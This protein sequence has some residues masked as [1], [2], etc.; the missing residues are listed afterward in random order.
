MERYKN[1]NGRSKEIKVLMPG[2]G[3]E[4]RDDEIRKRRS[5]IPAGGSDPPSLP[6]KGPRSA[7]SSY[8]HV[9][10]GPGPV[11]ICTVWLVLSTGTLRF[12]NSQIHPRNR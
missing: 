2:V 10:L 4:D 7:Q 8:T 6:Q 9:D 1:S 12:T 3:I 11:T 5:G